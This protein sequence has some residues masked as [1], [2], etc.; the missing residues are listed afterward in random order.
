MNT[1]ETKKETHEVM[2]GNWA[3][4]GTVFYEEVDDSFDHL[5]GVEY[6]SHFDIVDVQLDQAYWFDSEGQDHHVDLKDVPE[7]VKSTAVY[8]LMK[9]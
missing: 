9:E 1:L 4:T 3:I 2:V 5:F 7:S 6:L 8:L